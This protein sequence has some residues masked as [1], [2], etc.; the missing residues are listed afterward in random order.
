MLARP[1]LARAWRV[2]GPGSPCFR[3]R[4]V[5][6]SAVASATPARPP[7]R[8]V[9]PTP[10]K[11]IHVSKPDATVDALVA[12]WAAKVRRYAP[13]EDVSI[14]PNPGRAADPAAAVASEGARVLKA[15]G[16]SDVVVAL[17]ERG[18]E[19]TSASIADLLAA[20][21]GAGAGASSALEVR[22]GPSASLVFL[23]G[24][25]FGHAPAV[26]AR[27]DATLR[28]SGCVLNH[29]IA[30]VVLVEQLYR[31]WTILRGEPYHH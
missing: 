5:V 9:R 15:L 30:R 17:D 29:A 14:R 26:R 12:E 20:A 4:L 10:L 18:K 7:A 22:G 21:G 3:P 27:A 31:G 16:P 13:L 28:L 6:T 11:L 23:V 1:T 8:A 25:P 24:G 19:A 2:R